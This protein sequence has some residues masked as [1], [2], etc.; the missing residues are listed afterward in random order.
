MTMDE[1]KALCDTHI[2]NTY[3][4]RKLA[5]VRGEGARLWDADGREYLDFFAGIAVVN[6]GHCHPA[7]TDALCE[8]ARK[9]VHVSNLYYIEPQIELAALLA[10]HSFAQ[11]WFFC[12]CGATANEA[13]IKLARRY[14]WR[15]GQYKPSIITMDHS[16]HGRTLAA[17]TAT[18]QPKY[19]EGFQPLVPG[20]MYAPYDDL[21]TLESIITP[22]VGA[23]MLEAVQ[24]EGGVRVP[25]QGYLQAV[26]ELCDK[27]NLLLILDEVQTGFGRTGKLFAHEH[28]GIAPDIM[29]VAKALG[30]GVPIGALGCTEEVSSGFSP[31][32]HASTFGGNPL[33]TVAALATVK[34]LTTPGFLD[35]VAEKGSYFIHSLK[36]LV[37]KHADIAQVRGVGMMIGVELTRD[38]APIVAR[39]LESGVICGPAGP[40]VIRFVPPLIV[41]KEQIN[42]AA[43]SLDAALGEA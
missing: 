24:G 9:L 5:F 8:Q 25:S 30:N 41:T 14:W 4:P 7:V 42:R 6:L 12:N 43:E 18:A 13:A 31:G 38:V 19:Q 34:T 35:D 39:M 28:A 1:M 40:R 32:M 11:R 10:K 15:K 33:C 22:D 21:E 20:F 27:R 2:L 26:R 3:G 17:I 36:A 23:I 16:F 37:K 29:T